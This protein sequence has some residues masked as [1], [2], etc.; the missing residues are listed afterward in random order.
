MV[1]RSR[2]KT[3]HYRISLSAHERQQERA[4]KMTE[5][6]IDTELLIEEVRRHPELWDVGSEDYKNKNKKTAAWIEVCSTLIPDFETKEEAIKNALGKY[7]HLF[8]YRNQT[9]TK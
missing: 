8:I 4:V 5:R 2:G 1:R 7:K 6:E 3:V 9:W